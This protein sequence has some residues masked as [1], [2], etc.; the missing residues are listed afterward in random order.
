MKILL[1]ILFITCGTFCLTAQTPVKT[2]TITSVKVPDIVKKAFA[3]E[4]PTI[5]ATWETDDKNYKAIYADPKSNSKGII[6]YD[7]EG[8]VIR[9]DAEVNTSAKPE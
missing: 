6:I 8:K 1:L 5:Q 7:A 3:T 9:R 4:F 2:S